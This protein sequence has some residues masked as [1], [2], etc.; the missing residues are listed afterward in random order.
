MDLFSEIENDL[1]LIF[2]DIGG[3][4]VAYKCGFLNEV[5]A[6]SLFIKL[7]REV[8]WQQES[9]MMYGKEINFPRLISWYA[10]ESLNYSFSGITM[11]PHT[12][13]NELLEIKTKVEDLVGSTFNSL[14]INYYRSGMDSISWH[15]DNEKEFGVNPVIA[16]VS[17]GSERTFKL[18]RI[19]DTAQ[20]ISFDLEPGSLIVMSGELQVNWQHSL[21]KR[22]KVKEGRINLTF[23]KI[24]L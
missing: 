20:V 13:T 6:S 19:N 1:P 24:V 15:Q 2:K 23:R 8:N 9:M 14:L 22:T 5:E 16:S 7:K 11:K 4:N 17:L 18:R 21:P 3:G 10:D 12:W